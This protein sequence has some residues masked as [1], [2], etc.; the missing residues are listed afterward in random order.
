LEKVLPFGRLISRIAG[1]VFIA[2]GIWLLF[3]I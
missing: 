2:G 3:R 1:C